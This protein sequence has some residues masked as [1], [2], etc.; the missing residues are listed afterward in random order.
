MVTAWGGMRVF[1]GS[2]QMANK[3]QMMTHRRCRLSSYSRA[4]ACRVV[5]TL[6]GRPLKLLWLVPKGKHT[7]DSMTFWLNVG[8]LWDAVLQRVVFLGQGFPPPFACNCSSWWT[9][10]LFSEWHGKGCIFNATVISVLWKSLSITAKNLC[11]FLE[12]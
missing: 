12:H 6:A 11:L 2:I 7:S 8:F 3:S 5:T 1:L 4:A 10:K 9:H